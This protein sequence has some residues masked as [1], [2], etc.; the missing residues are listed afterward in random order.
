M[1]Q[2]ELIESKALFD[3]GA[4]A[5]AAYSRTALGR[6]RHEVTW[7]NIS[8]HLPATVEGEPPPQA[9][10]AGGGSGEIALQLVQQGYRVFLLDC[11]PG[12]LDLAGQAA[13]GLEADL[14]TR[15]TTCLISAEDAPQHFNPGS[16]DAITCHTLI[17]YLPEPRGTLHGLAHL[18]RDGG[19]LSVS[20]VNRHGEVLR[21]AW[22]QDDPAGA[23][24]SLDNATF[25]AALFHLE[26]T[27]YTAEEV[28]TWLVELGL[29]VI[30][31][32][33]VRVFAD[34][35]P[36]ERLEE[37]AFFD[38]I[39]RLEKAV[40]ERPPYRSMA[41]YAHLIARKEAPGEVMAPPPAH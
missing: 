15:L 3:A 37:P 25:C 32:C 23:L 35:V 24:A 28:E 22:L 4:Q 2:M 13:E 21:R 31:R 17:E 16:F 29:T 7:H 1:A 30:A 10:D 38:A 27:A 19:L 9:L 39:L 33:G 34:Y 18:L 20:F 26:G 8:L 12:M 40:A 6:I 5:W 41:R 11:A 14:R 36:R